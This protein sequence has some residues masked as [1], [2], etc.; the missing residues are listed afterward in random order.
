M[1]YITTSGANQAVES[2][3][4]T[5][6]LTLRLTLNLLLLYRL[7]NYLYFVFASVCNGLNPIKISLENQWQQ[8]CSQ[9][10]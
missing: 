2:L 1:I 6:A 5:P 9:T 7:H 8:K 3:K 10:F 4:V